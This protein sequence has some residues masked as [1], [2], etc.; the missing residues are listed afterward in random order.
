MAPP[1]PPEPAPERELEPRSHLGELQLP[2]QLSTALVPQQGFSGSS[3]ALALGTQQPPEEAG[4]G[5]LALQ[6][7][8]ASAA[9]QLAFEKGLAQLQEDALGL[10]RRAAE[11]LRGHACES[12]EGR[13]AL[14][15]SAA[16]AIVA[17]Q[18]VELA[19]EMPAEER[20][21]R[22]R[23]RVGEA[24][25]RIQQRE[26]LQMKVHMLEDA[27]VRVLTRAREEAEQAMLAAEEKVL[28]A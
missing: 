4:H 2:G 14:R 13:Q 1:P 18:L 19:P 3:R 22:V 26:R 20:R 15:G 8:H 21:A 5:T 10:R 25:A 27:A 23:W 12:R 6:A 7:G 9:H 28:P 24:R 11:W 16:L 17:Q